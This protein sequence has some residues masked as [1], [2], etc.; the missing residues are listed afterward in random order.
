MGEREHAR[1]GY[2][3]F[4]VR[5]NQNGQGMSS[6]SSGRGHMFSDKNVDNNK[7]K[8]Q[9]TPQSN[10]L[11]RPDKLRP[12]ITDTLQIF[13]YPGRVPIPLS[14][15]KRGYRY[16]DPHSKTCCALQFHLHSW[17]VGQKET[18]PPGHTRRRTERLRPKER[19]RRK[20]LSCTDTKEN[21]QT[22]D[23]RAGS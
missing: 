7:N 2:S 9:L 3:L 11:P 20:H 6:G 12:T 13:Y 17:L 16:T 1:I 18:N 21:I 8:K 15:G 4:T 22:T 19:E 23:R 5:R 14:Q 10:D